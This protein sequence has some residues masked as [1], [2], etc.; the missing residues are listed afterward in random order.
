M[1]VMQEKEQ[2]FFT[3][4]EAIT[5]LREKRGLIFTVGSLR[6]RRRRG[7]ASSSRVLG[8]MKLFRLDLSDKLRA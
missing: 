4:A 1:L 2:T 8:R 5:Y 3:P 7:Q 6:N